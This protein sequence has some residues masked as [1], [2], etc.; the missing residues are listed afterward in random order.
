MFR[1]L[2]F[3]PELPAEAY[4]AVAGGIYLGSAIH[5][6]D[7]ARFVMGEVEQSARWA[8]R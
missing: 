8:G 3:D 2:S 1:S 7:T 6:I 5:D 4:M